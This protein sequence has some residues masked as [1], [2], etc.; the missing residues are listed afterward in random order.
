M[1]IK[2]REL[3]DECDRLQVLT[4]NHQTMEN[5]N[6]LL[7]KRII[8]LHSESDQESQ[9]FQEFQ[10][11]QESQE[12][13]EKDEISINVEQLKVVLC[14]RLKSYHEK[15]IDNLIQNYE[16]ETKSS[17]DKETMEKLLMEAIHL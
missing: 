16:L 11:F 17:I 4:M 8:E 13:Q 5:E 1:K 10:E 2:N 14:N 3:Q 7:K 6:S 9:E 12:S 15:H